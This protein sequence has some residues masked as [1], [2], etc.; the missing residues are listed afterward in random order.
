VY[1]YFDN[2][3]KLHAPDNARELMAKLGLPE[4]IQKS[5]LLSSDEKVL[6]L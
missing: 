3:D 2:T 5:S 1:C 6:T 4:T